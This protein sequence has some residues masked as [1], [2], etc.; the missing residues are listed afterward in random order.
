MDISM[1]EMNIVIK[2]LKKESNNTR[3][4]SELGQKQILELT[5]TI[6]EFRIDIQEMIK[7]IAG[8]I[9]ELKQTHKFSDTIKEIANTTN[10]LALNASIEAARAGEAGRGFSVV[11]V[12]IRKLAELSTLSTEKIS[13]QLSLFSEKSEKTRTKMELIAHR[14]S[15]SYKMTEQTSNIFEE[16][17]IA[18]IN[19]NNLTLSNDR[20]GSKIT[21]DIKT[22]KISTHELVSISEETGASIE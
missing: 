21:H 11:A 19:L 12:E 15:E 18:I 8:L 10:L 13:E 2:K 4:L 1:E 14:M 7:D 17:N 3:D 16:I 5:S 9:D 20:I 22:I 6:E